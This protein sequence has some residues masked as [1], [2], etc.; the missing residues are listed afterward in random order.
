M[1][2]WAVINR[3]ME[4]QHFILGPE[5]EAL[6]DEVARWLGAKAAVGCASGSDALLLGLMGLGVQAGDEVVTTPF[7]FVATAG[8]IARLDAR[9]VFVD[10]DP[11]TYNID[12]GQIEDAISPRTRAI[13]P[14]H[15]FGL[16][17]DMGAILDI[18]SRRGLNVIEDADRAGDRGPLQKT[19]RR[20]CAAGAPASAR[21]AEYR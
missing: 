15:L 21:R 19:L 18:A 3:V 4:Q 5:V 8:S 10:I 1:K 7:T 12:V 11:E 2:S 9:P 13:M 20:A 16:A 14:V 17:A 6:E